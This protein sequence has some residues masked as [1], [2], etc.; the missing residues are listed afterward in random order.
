M[1]GIIQ[2]I[3]S[4]CEVNMAQILFCSI[5]LHTFLILKEIYINWIDNFFSNNSLPL[6]IASNESSAVT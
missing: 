1:D 6:F 4:D 5:N 2:L 3:G